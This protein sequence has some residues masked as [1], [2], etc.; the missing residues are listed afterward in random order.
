MKHNYTNH[1]VR[2]IDLPLK[3]E[4]KLKKTNKFNVFSKQPTKSKL[5]T[6]VLLTFLNSNLAL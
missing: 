3:F 5:F 4:L 6:V 1:V 2:V